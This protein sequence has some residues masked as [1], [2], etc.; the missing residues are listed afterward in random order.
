MSS[1][2]VRA[3]PRR[4]VQRAVAIERVE[5]WLPSWLQQWCYR[6]ELRATRAATKAALSFD[7][8]VREQVKRHDD[9][10]KDAFRGGVGHVRESWGVLVPMAVA[11][12]ATDAHGVP[13]LRKLA[14]AEVRPISNA[15]VA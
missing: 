1:T 7:D 3:L 5:S 12:M 4:E 15:T 14:R 8:R 11:D 2:H 10:P 6:R 9:C 13:H